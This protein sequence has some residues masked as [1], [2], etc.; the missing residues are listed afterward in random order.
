MT[1]RLDRPALSRA[2]DPRVRGWLSTA[3]PRLLIDNQWVPA[4]SGQT[5][6]VIDPVTEGVLAV[7]ASAQAED[8]DA[9]VRAARRAFE[10][11]SWPML[12]PAQRA[13]LLRKFG[14][15]LEA[16]AGQLA[17]L[18][19]LNNGMTLSLAKELI[20]AATETVYYY[21][22]ATTLLTGETA[23]SDPGFFNY[24]LREPLG[25]CAA[26]TPWNGPI[27]SAVQKIA[28]AL[29]AGN[30]LVLKPAEQTPL[31]ALRL[32]ELA[33][34]A[35]F[36]PGVLNVVTGYGETAGA[37]LVSHA[38]VDKIAFTG[39]TTVGKQILA[40]SSGSLKRV[41]L[42]LGGK[43]PNIVFPDA[44]LEQA[45]PATMLGYAIL[46]GQVC[47]AGTRVFVQREFKDE[48]VDRLVEIS[49]SIVV[50]DPLDEATT[51]GPLASR[52][53]FDR[54]CGYLQAGAAEGAVARTG[55]ASL[56]G[57]GYFVQP[58]VFDEVQNSYSTGGDLRSRRIG[59][60]LQRRARR[61]AAGQ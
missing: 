59:H 26:I 19:S 46:T 25:V 56:P 15:L 28:P 5:F 53:Q 20:G 39:S 6:E 12:T 55:G 21:A 32:G 50:G 24:T 13:R 54:V 61:G 29:A 52:E 57:A 37:S 33:L 23:A 16:H 17:E 40:A 35:G 7:V 48:F 2:R 8:V 42:E 38:D 27:N 51:M 11:G 3:Q 34:E 47:C 9:A 30:T 1:T 58:T 31:S 14:D 22:G 43:S 44:N 60:P 41:T 49:R 45:L 10:G 36:P 18:E 4:L